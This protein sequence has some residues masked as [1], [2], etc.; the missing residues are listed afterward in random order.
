VAVFLYKKEILK[1]VKRRELQQ[2]FPVSIEGQTEHIFTFLYRGTWLE[3]FPVSV[4]R[5]WDYNNFNS[6]YRGR[7]FQN[8][9]LCTKCTGRLGGTKYFLV[10]L[11][12]G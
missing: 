8:I 7:L 3:Y 1:M 4:R 11:H 2:L 6:L 5:D 9:C 12:G 10:S